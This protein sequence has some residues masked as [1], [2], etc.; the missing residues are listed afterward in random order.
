MGSRWRQGGRY[1]CR[2]S[3]GQPESEDD[4][5]RRRSCGSKYWAC[6]DPDSGE[7]ENTAQDADPSTGHMKIK[8]RECVKFVKDDATGAIADQGNIAA[9]GP[10]E[11]Y[12]ENTS[13]GHG[14][15]MCNGKSVFVVQL[16]AQA[17]PRKT[18]HVRFDEPNANERTLVFRRLA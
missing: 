11:S 13:T 9:F 6:E 5:R 14:I 1:G 17:G 4:G 8:A 3:G 18:E 12:T 15:P 7:S 10:Q 2:R 16:D